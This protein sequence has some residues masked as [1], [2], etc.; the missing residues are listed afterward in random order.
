VAEQDVDCVVRLEDSLVDVPGEV[1]ETFIAA[2]ARAGSVAAQVHRDDT[3]AVLGEPRSDPP[4]GTRRGG[5][6]VDEHGE[7][8]VC[9]APVPGRKAQKLSTAGRRS[10]SSVQAVGSWEW[11]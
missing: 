4:P 6:P 2:H 8:P 1:V 9:L 10:S 7:R 5:D 11:I 3:P